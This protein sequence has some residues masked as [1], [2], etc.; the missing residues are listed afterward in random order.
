M[1]CSSKK[2]LDFPWERLHQLHQMLA[3]NK[4]ILDKRLK[5]PL[6]NTISIETEQSGFSL[7]I[8]CIA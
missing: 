8:K 2:N 5:K 6:I 4:E 1:V 7:Q 3:K